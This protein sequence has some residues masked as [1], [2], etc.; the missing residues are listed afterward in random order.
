MASLAGKADPTLA[1]MAYAAGMANVPGDYSKYYQDIADQHKKLMGGIETM[2]AVFKLENDLAT[3]EFKKAMDIFNDPL[4]LQMIDADYEEMQTDITTQRET[5]KANKGFKNDP[6]GRQDWNRRNLEIIGRH[7]QDNS[8][9]E[10]LHE[11]FK[12]NLYNIEHMEIGKKKYLTYLA[13][14]KTNQDK[15]S[16]V[17]NAAATKYMKN[18]P[19]A[20]KEELWKSLGILEEGVTVKFKDPSTG[21]Y[22]YISKVGEETS[23]DAPYLPRGKGMPHEDGETPPTTTTPLIISKKSSELLEYFNEDARADSALVQA[24]EQFQNIITNAKNTE[25][26]YDG[27]KTRDINDLERI[28]DT[29]ML[30]N[31][32]T[33]KYMYNHKIG[34][35]KLTFAEALRSG[36][37]DIGLTNEIIEALGATESDGDNIL[38][39]TDFATAQS[40]NTVVN[41]ILSDEAVGEDKE[42]NP[43]SVDTKGLYLEYTSKHAYE[44]GHNQ[45]KKEKSG[46]NGNGDDDGDD[47]NLGIADWTYPEFGNGKINWT[48]A[49]TLK[50][51]LLDGTYFEFDSDGDG[52]ME[53]YDFIDGKWHE[54][55]E[56][57]DNTGTEI[58][59]ADDMVVDVFKTNHEAFQGLTTT[60][61]NIEG[62]IGVTGL[63]PAEA[64]KNNITKALKIEGDDK[65][66][67]KLNSMFGGLNRDKDMM[68]VPYSSDIG[69]EFY[70]FGVSDRAWSNDIT[71]IDPAT[72]DFI[73]D[74]NGNPYRFSTGD[75]FNSKD[76][77]R[78]LNALG[79]IAIPTTATGGGAAK[80]N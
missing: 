66:S 6:E 35:E 33:Y 50:R 22:T 56:N 55:W 78:I 54:N 46:G 60:P 18:N 19:D 28:H 63:K 42:G 47:K 76:I 15:K 74:E 51:R 37:D 68:F 21:E 25:L 36:K 1:R 16:G 38:E 48:S 4:N 24:R 77:Q 27:F 65:V 3:Q 11:S 17:Y 64:Q 75:K 9:L 44:A 57:E 73:L 5:W 53:T 20:T 70:S 62:E 32:N 14:Y 29:E 49:R 34:G 41:S 72:K 2:A 39:V 43:I 31:P 59:S 61:V 45:Y 52:E 40:Y 10:I 8:N 69:G 79:R 80:F 71:L 26:G 23:T 12:G 67:A 13:K 30:D 7:E 58:G